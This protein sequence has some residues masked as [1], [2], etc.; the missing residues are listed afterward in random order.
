MHVIP[1]SLKDNK[2]YPMQFRTN[3]DFSDRGLIKRYH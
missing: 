3:L 1:Y 2:A